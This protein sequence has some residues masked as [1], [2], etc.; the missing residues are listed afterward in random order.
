MFGD[1]EKTEIHFILANL[2]NISTGCINF[3]VWCLPYK[4]VSVN[5]DVVGLAGKRTLIKRGI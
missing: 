3:I 2:S 1:R 5:K 4:F